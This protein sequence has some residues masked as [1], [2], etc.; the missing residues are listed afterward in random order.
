M[1]ISGHT[2][3][4]AFFAD[5]AEHSASPAMYNAC[6]RKMNTD[7]VYLAFR[8]GK[9]GIRGAMESMRLLDIKGANIS[10]PN[11]QEVIKYL[12]EISDEAR[13]CGAVNTVVNDSGRLKGYNTDIFGAVRAVR[14][15][16]AGISGQSVCIFGLGGAGRAIL[17]G[18]AFQ[19]ASHISVIVRRRRAEEH[20]AFTSVIS[21]A[22]GVDIGIYDI[23]DPEALKRETLAA[24]IVINATDV[25]MGDDAGSSVIP[26]VT[27]LK[28]G[29]Y[30]MDAVYSPERTRLMDIAERAG[31]AAKNGRDMLIF[32]GA[33]AFRLYTGLEM[34]LNE[35]LSKE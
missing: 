26:D 14:G 4:Y 35:V 3:L 23:E 11:K 33:E 12:D 15:M 32:Q 29:Q 20:R 21:D 13:L 24:D 10:M 34:P 7:A 16:G 19:G 17:T 8:V 9:E 28:P 1:E 18:M 2:A 30:V 25:G 27:Y 22:S 6:F 31:A 5:P